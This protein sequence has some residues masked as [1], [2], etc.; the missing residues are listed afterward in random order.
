MKLSSTHKTNRVAFA[1]RYLSQEEDFSKWIFSDEK[2]F[3]G[4]GPDNLGT[5]LIKN[6]PTPA[7]EKRQCGGVSVMVIGCIS[8][9]GNLMIKVNLYI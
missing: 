9:K 3:N 6:I 2:K 5:Y 1:S 8:S 4:D 7:R